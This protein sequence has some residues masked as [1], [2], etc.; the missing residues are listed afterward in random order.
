MI[1][2]TPREASR[3]GIDSVHITDATYVTYL[4]RDCIPVYLVDNISRSTGDEG[5]PRVRRPTN[6][7]LPPSAQTT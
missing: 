6:S 3:E 2:Q 4:G 7:S 1:F 5:K